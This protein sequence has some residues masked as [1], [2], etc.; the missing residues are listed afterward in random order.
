MSVGRSAS[1]GKQRGEQAYYMMTRLLDCSEGKKKKSKMVLLPL[2]RAAVSGAEA[3]AAAVE[4]NDD[5][6]GIKAHH[7]R[8]IT[9]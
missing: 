8:S 9:G 3:A 4:E 6:K 1:E 7:Y 5:G 2:V